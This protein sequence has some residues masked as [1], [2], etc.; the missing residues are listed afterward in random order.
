MRRF[1]YSSFKIIIC[2]YAI[3]IPALFIP[4][5]LKS[6]E[7][8][9]LVF[10]PEYAS[11]IMDSERGRILF[12]KFSNEPK[13]PASLVKLMTLYL[14]FEALKNEKID[15]NDKIKV[16]SYAASVEKSNLDLKAGDYLTVKQ[17]IDA[18]I[19]KSAN[20]AAI[21]IAEHLKESE[22]KF[23]KQMNKTAKKLG[24]KHTKFFNSSGLPHK[25]QLST[26]HDMAILARAIKNHFPQHFHLFSKTSFK[27][28]NKKYYTS[29]NF[30]KN[31]EGADGLKTGFT[32]DSGYN[33]IVTARRN[34]R[35]II[36]VVMGMSFIDQRDKHVKIL[37]DR[38]FNKKK[39]L[40]KQS[41]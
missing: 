27:F 24:M 19:V 21:A 23:V 25:E 10:A 5:I 8:T 3:L 37:L 36:C 1:L 33:I 13:Y 20:D 32:F 35:H 28:R 15:W 2:I 40:P 18:L 22:K 12:E 41:L 17:I 6:G 26:S 16:S 38:E 9:Y 39:A 7:D 29:N 31:Y 34:G 30:L 11:T 14:T 4:T